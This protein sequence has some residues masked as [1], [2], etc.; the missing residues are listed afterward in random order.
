MQKLLDA[1]YQTHI[2]D[3]EAFAAALDDSNDLQGRG[4]DAFDDLMIEKF[5]EIP[6]RLL[7]DLEMM[8][9]ETPILV[10]VEEDGSWVLV[11]GHHRLAWA[12]VEKCQVPV[13]FVDETV[14]PTEVW[15][16]M[17]DSEY[18]DYA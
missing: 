1:G 6:P 2:I 7:D 5:Q 3:A 15:L 16:I 4:M 14:D 8:G 10:S 12:L 11:D 18:Y 17:D 9:I 13:F